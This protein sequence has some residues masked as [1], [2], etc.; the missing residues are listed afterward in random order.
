MPELTSGQFQ[1]V[2]NMLSLSIASML[3]AFA[4]FVMARGQLAPKYRPAMIMS[5]LVVGI[6]GY[7]YWRIFNSWDG[8]YELTAAGTYAATGEPFND[9]YRYVDWLLTVPL[10]VAELV[11]VLALAR[12][13][14]GK[15]MAKLVIAATAM[16]AL[17]Y[18]GEI[19]S[20]PTARTV[21]GLLSTVPFVYIV[22]VLWTQLGAAAKNNS[23]R[24]RVLLRN[25]QLLLLATWGFYPIAYMMPLF[26]IG[27]GAT[28]EVALQVGYSL[29]DILAKCGYG[30]MIYN[31]ARSKMEAEG[32]DETGAV[33]APTTAVAA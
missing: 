23:E 27:G 9:A 17:G 15:M 4:F 6:A 10:L 33:A 21:W 20:D 31:I 14:R 5:A 3:G 13:V 19:T 18:P 26:G 25:T 22:Y 30:L 24:T 7:H 28:A 12:A 11:A 2:Y 8:A 1:L 16:I 29:A 32:V